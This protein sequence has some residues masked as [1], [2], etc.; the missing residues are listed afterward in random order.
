MS[1][2][3]FCGISVKKHLT[4]IVELQDGGRH[5]FSDRAAYGFPYYISF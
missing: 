1:V 4:V 2:Y 5:I 3:E